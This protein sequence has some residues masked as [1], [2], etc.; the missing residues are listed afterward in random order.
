MTSRSSTVLRSRFLRNTGASAALL[1]PVVAGAI[2]TQVAVPA[3]AQSTAQISGTVTDPTGA[4]IPGAKVSIRETSTNAAREVTANA[5]GIFSLTNLVPGHYQLTATSAG[6]ADF[7]A[8]LDVTIGASI[9]LNPKLSTAGSS[10]TV[11]VT[12]NDAVQVNTATPEVSQVIT[13]EQITALPSLT[14]NPY[15]FVALSGNVSSGDNTAAGAAQNGAN[16]GVNFSLNGQ[17]NSG[18]EILL[19]GVENIQVFGDGV[20]II[21]PIDDV[22]EYRVI[23]NNYP[24]Q[25]G[26]A[27]GGVVSVSTN[28]GTNQFHGRAWEFNRISSLASNT[29]TNSQLG[30]PKGVFTRNQF[31]GAVGGPIIKNKLFFFA[32]TE[33]TRIRSASPNVSVIPSPQLLAA[34]PANIQSFFS[35][36]AGPTSA[37]VLS[38]TTNLQAGGGTTPLYSPT[39]YPALTPSTPVFNVVQFNVPADAGGGIPQNTYNITGRV[40]YN[41]SDRTQMFFRYVDYHEQDQSG[42]TFN[43]PYSQYNV[44]FSNISSAYLYSVAHQFSSSVSSLT[45]LSFSRFNQADSYNTALQS[46]PTLV[47]APNAVDPFSGRPFQLPGFYDTNPAN[48]GLPYG[49][50]QNTI[51]WN[52]DVAVSKGKHQIMVGGQV[53]YI[54]ENSA[55][56]AYAQAN[57]QLG[58]SQT[59]GLAAF[60]TGNLY[61]FQAAVNPQGKYPCVKNQYTGSYTITA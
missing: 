19:D 58:S 22:Q 54:Q 20:G 3:Y 50:P 21:V 49:G 47:I 14:R 55:Y 41:L 4:N 44:A 51:Q 59:K 45:K 28:A 16:R 9:T 8:T 13:T 33:L 40:D 42:S 30:I 18:T 60:L 34:A 5:D 12:A 2:A 52:Q 26:R 31:G 43:S 57:E 11:E 24:A 35:T 15:D 10:T 1:L 37:T 61:E 17:R 38:Q 32:T 56:G 29:V 23:T 36:Y 27:S 53:L 7:N 25:Y 6:F 46:T 48:G 39:L